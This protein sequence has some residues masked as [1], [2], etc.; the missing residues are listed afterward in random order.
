MKERSGNIFINNFSKGKPP[1]LPFDTL[2]KAVL[3][4]KYELSV[5]FVGSA[6]SKKLNSKYRNKRKPANILSFPLSKT[7]GEIIICLP[8]AKKDAPKFGLKYEEF[9]PFLFI[10]GLLHL[11]G[12]RHSSK[13]EDKEAATF[14]KFGFCR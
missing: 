5:A 8:E 9:I 10:H 13:M 6:E 11:K 2:K 14:R 1:R 3:G 7:E 12:M 4:D